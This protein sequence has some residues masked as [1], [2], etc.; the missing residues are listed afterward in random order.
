MKHALL[1]ASLLL[2]AAPLTAQHMPPG[3]WDSPSRWDRDPAPRGGGRAEGKVETETFASTAA[4]APALGQGGIAIVPPAAPGDFG[5]STAVFESALLD[6]LAQHG[7]NTAVSAAAAPQTAELRLVREIAV[8]EEAPRKP[9]SGV[10][11]TTVSNRGT[12]FGIGLSVDLS[13]PRKAMVSTR[14]EARIRDARTQAVIWEGRAEMLSREGSNRWTD[15]AIA[16]RLATALFREF[17][18]ADAPAN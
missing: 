17:P 14:I 11:E 16:E 15:Q 1:A 8:P 13:K 4:D 5:G 12:G 18:R 9:V 3:A 7:Y 10:M 6:Q 2:V